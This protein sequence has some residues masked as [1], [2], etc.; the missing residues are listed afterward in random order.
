VALLK[1][2]DRDD[3]SEDRGLYLQAWDGKSSYKLQRVIRG[4]RS[5][6]RACV[7]MLGS[8]QPGVIA[9]YLQRAIADG[10][11]NDGLV[12]RFS[13]LVWPDRSP[14]WKDIDR[15]PD[16]D[17]RKEAWETFQRLS[18][19]DPAKVGATA[20]EFRDI[21]C[22]RFM[23]GA[24]ERFREW[25]KAHE[26]KLQSGNLHPA[27]ESHLTKYRKLVPTLALINHLAEGGTGNV[28][29][30]SLENA[31]AF[32]DYLETHARRAYGSGIMVEVNVAKAILKRIQKGDIEDGFAARDVYRNGWSNLS[33]SEQVQAGINLLAECEWLSER[34]DSS[35]K[36][37]GRPKTYYKIN[38]AAF[39]KPTLH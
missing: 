9:Q 6:D 34:E 33:D 16:P 35:Q 27:L 1:S 21:P 23:A 2:L 31:I 14:D 12:Q 18:E 10:I 13:L 37:S 22:V 7:S 8:T 3:R 19:L 29:E 26:H 28:W 11:G 25:R 32:S 5:V 4:L 15:Y 39:R 36:V 30:P 17:K 20:D 38:P 24:Q